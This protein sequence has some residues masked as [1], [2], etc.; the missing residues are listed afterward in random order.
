MD[1]VSASAVHVFVCAGGRLLPRWREAFPGA[2]GIESGCAVRPQP[3]LLWVRV[4][5]SAPVADQLGQA[6]RTA[7]TAPLV[8]LS[9]EP[10]DAEALAALAAGA[11]GYCNAHAGPEFLRQVAGVVVQGGLWIGES[12]MTRLL[13]L[14]GGL[15]TPFEARVDWA[16]KL[17]GRECEVARAVAKGAS[18]KEIARH[19]G[20]TERTI[21][22]HLAAIFEK[23]G[24]RDRL[25]LALRVNGR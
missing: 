4:D 18:N 11:R 7:P 19:L 23:L 25:R 5:K 10:H 21:K 9:D 24:V 3:V 13:T 14:V 22:A 15:P 1:G 8:V 2:R 16:E 6:R 12:L 20:I 17:T